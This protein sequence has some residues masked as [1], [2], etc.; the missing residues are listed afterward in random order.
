ML[1]VLAVVISIGG[2]VLVTAVVPGAVRTAIWAR[3]AF[4]AAVTRTAVSIASVGAIS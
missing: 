4:R 2:V 3:T 1:H